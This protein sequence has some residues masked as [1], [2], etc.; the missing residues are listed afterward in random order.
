M[1]RGSAPST[2]L[3]GSA[4]STPLRVLQTA[5]Q[6]LQPRLKHDNNRCLTFIILG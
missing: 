6:A 5:P 4:P 3:R 2:P 1:V